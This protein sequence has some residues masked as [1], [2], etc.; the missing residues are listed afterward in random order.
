MKRGVMADDSNSEGTGTP[1]A[2]QGDPT[3]QPSTGQPPPGEQETQTVVQPPPTQDTEKG[4]A[5]G[6]WLAVLAIVLTSVV[7]F[8]AML[9]FNNV[10]KNATDVTTVLSA[11]FTI[12]GTVVGTY[13]GIK[14]SGDTRDKTQ[15]AIER[16][17]ETANRALAE[18]SPEAGRRI[19]RG[20]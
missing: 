12:V 3:V 9:I 20:G 16:A 6:F 4:P 19:V 1:A 2:G 7:A 5:Y 11:L 10:F 18:L 17:N 15:G 8:A 14:T 13:F